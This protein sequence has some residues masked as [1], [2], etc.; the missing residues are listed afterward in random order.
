MKIQLI[1]YDSDL[2]PKR[3]RTV[4]S[5]AVN[6][7]K[8]DLI[9]FPGKSLRNMD[10]LNMLESEITNDKSLVV[11]ELKDAKL[12]NGRHF[13]NALF[14]YRKGKFEC[15]F[16]SQFFAN[17]DDING[18]ESLMAELFE[19]IPRRQFV[20]R[21]KRFTVLQCGETALLACPKS[22]GYKARFRFKDNRE[23]NKR[24]EALLAS[25]DV[26]LNPIHDLQGEQGVMAKRR[27]AL[28]ADGRYYL[29]TSA[30][31]D[32]MTGKFN[33]KRIQYICHNGDELAIKPD[34]HENEGFISRIVE[35]K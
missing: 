13:H 10:D 3:K 23:L 25:T 12:D 17:A 22:E 16:T 28:S 6:E 15:L 21:G 5:K 32:K 19:E 27:A 30:L 14:L 26:F 9:V 11:F 20:H 34:I 7:S 8:A 35:I 18:N 24:Y 33:S 31:N 4:F 2:S 29:S 1:G